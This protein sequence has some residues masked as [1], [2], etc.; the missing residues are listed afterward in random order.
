MSGQKKIIGESITV[1]MDGGWTLSGVVKTSESNKIVISNDGELYLIFKSK[2]CAMKLS[3][4]EETKSPVPRKVS[5][6]KN[7]FPENKLQYNEQVMSIP[8]SLLNLEK[9]DEEDFSISFGGSSDIKDN[10]TNRIRFG[11]DEDT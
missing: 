2:V 4:G 6:K 5:E 7:H 1:Y 11:I 10:E 8:G 3:A 9:E